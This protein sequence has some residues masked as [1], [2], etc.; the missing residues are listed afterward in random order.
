MATRQDLGAIPDFL[1][2]DE[3]IGSDPANANKTDSRLSRR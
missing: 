2:M 1:R 3:A